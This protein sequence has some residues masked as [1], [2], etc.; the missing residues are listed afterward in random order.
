VVRKANH[1]L[2]CI[3]K[4][5]A[6]RSR[7]EGSDDFPVIGTGEATSGVRCPVWGIPAQEGRQQIGGGPV[8]RHWAAQG[9]C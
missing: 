6:R 4:N 3:S 5:V 1:I 7:V 2:G 9:A 8:E